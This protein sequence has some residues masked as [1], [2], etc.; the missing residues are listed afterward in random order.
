MLY[1]TFL[2]VEGVTR[3]SLW[4]HAPD[5]RAAVTN[6]AITAHFTLT[7][8]LLCRDNTD[9]PPTPEGC[10][11]KVTELLKDRGPCPQKTHGPVKRLLREVRY[12]RPGSQPPHL[13][14]RA[15]RPWLQRRTKCAQDCSLAPRALAQGGCAVTLNSGASSEARGSKRLLEQPLAHTNPSARPGECLEGV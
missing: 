4:L 7:R 2:L 3:S 13:I 10:L 1:V 9:R 5:T 11:T 6:G 14:P 8:R 12:L 15:P